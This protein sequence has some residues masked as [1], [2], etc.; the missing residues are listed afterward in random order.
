MSAWPSNPPL[1]D[2]RATCRMAR[3]PRFLLGSVR[4]AHEDSNPFDVRTAPALT[5][6]CNQVTESTG[7]DPR[8][9]RG[10]ED[11]IRRMIVHAIKYADPHIANNML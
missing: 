7:M 3:R 6:E 11:R 10:F 1:L 8:S 2:I 5:S 4:L 9:V